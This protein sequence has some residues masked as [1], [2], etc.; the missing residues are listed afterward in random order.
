LVKQKSI[1]LLNLMSYISNNE[2]Q[3]GSGLSAE[4]LSAYEGN[5]NHQKQGG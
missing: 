4:P 1:A 5:Q 3:R 2:G